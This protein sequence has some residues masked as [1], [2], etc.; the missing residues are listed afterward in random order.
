MSISSVS[1]KWLNRLYKTIAIFLV[2]VAVLISAFRLLL[3]YVENYRSD[4]QDYVNSRNDTNIQIGSLTMT[5]QRFGPSL[6][7]KDV[8]LIETD[9]ASVSIQQLEA[10]VDFWGSLSKQRLV[11][12]NLI[13][14]GAKVNVDQGLWQS[15]EAAAS[16]ATNTDSNQEE[17]FDGIVNLFL[18]RLNEFS[19]L[20]SQI[21]VRNKQLARKFHINNL[22]WLNSGDLHQAQGS[23][24]VNGLSSNNI[25][26]KI[27]LHGEQS[28][29][30]SGQLY[31]Q[32]NHLDITPW[33]DSVLA[34]DNDKTKSDISFAA[35]LNVT[36]SA[37]DRLQIELPQNSI[38]WQVEQVS[39]SLKLGQG[40]LL[41]VKGREPKSFKLFSTPLSLQFNE[42]PQQQLK[43][44]LSKKDNDFS[45]Y[46]SGV[47]LALVGQL[48][49]LFTSEPE[50]RKMLAQLSL[51]G[52][53]HDAYVNFAQG[54]LQFLADFKQ[55][56]NAYSHGIPG[57]SNLAGKLSYA[58]QQLFVSVN[59]ENGSLDFS[60]NFVA[61]IGYQSLSSKLDIAFDDQGWQLRVDALDIVS[62]ELTFAAQVK[63][64]SP[65]EGETTMA[66]L[67]DITRGNAALAGHYYPLN[68]MSDDLVGYLNDA[69][70]SGQIE[71]AAVLVNGPLSHFPFTDGSGIFVVDAELTDSTFK[72]ASD[73]PAITQFD[74]NLNFTNNSMLITG[75][76]GE[77]SGLNV[78]GV[79]AAIDD[80]G[81]EQVLTVAA[82]IKPS[83]ANLVHDLMLAS[84]LKDSVGSVLEQLQI[85]GDIAGEFHLD[86]PLNNSEQVLASGVIHFDDNDVALQTPRMDFSKVNGQLSFANDKITTQDLQLTWHDLPLALA[87]NGINKEAYYDTDIQI[88]TNWQQDNWQAHVPVLLKKYAGGQLPWQGALS[89]HQHHQGG[90]SYQFDLTS[91]FE[92]TKL[93]LPAPYGKTAEQ[94]KPFKVEVTGQLEQSQITAQL[95]NDLS[96]FGIL[97]HESTSFSRAH[98]VLGNEEMLLPMDGFHITTKLDQADFAYWQPLLSD[99]IDTVSHESSSNDGEEAGSELAANK[100]L[101]AKPERIRGTIEQME[102]FG[103][104][105]S[106]ISF[107][108]F[109]KTDWWLLQLN[110]TETRSQLKFY[111]NWHEQGVDINAEFIHLT[112]Q[113]DATQASEAQGVAS[114]SVTPVVDNKVIFANIPPLR[115]HCDRCQIDALDFGQVDFAIERISDEKIQIKQFN[116]Q[117]EQ[118]KLAFTGDWHLNEQSSTTSLRGDMSVDNIEYE[119]NQLGYESIIRDSGGKLDFNLNWHGGPH[120]FDVKALYGAF[121]ARIDDGYL[122]D[123]SDKARI[124]S[125]LSLQSLVRKLTLDFRDI[126]SDGMFYSDIKGE[127]HIE[128]GILYTDRTKMN[129]TAGNLD[130]TGSTDLSTGLL[131][132]KMSYKPNLTSS[133]PVLAWIATLNPVTFLA[134]VAI[135]QVIKSQVVSEFKFE[136]TGTV[137]EPNFQQIERKTKEVRVGRS[138]K[139][140]ILDESEQGKKKEL[141][142]KKSHLQQYEGATDADKSPVQLLDGTSLLTIPTE[143]VIHG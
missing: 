8:I 29:E 77:L 46:F 78:T 7:A 104:Q 20:N 37:I 111:P 30:L 83:G 18:N 135:D 125:I 27:S 19:I 43:V 97:E 140:E 126:F 96:F 142:P 3:P 122:A 85:A 57:M 39:Q 134:G 66:L 75:R 14:T 103:Q 137:S 113:P 69:L 36:N 138:K 68:L 34:I 41:L 44:M 131:D 38:D 32:A 86:L 50:Q 141:P 51:T 105:L 106:N 2:V 63:V 118:A 115:L 65:A 35:W 81:N 127:Y 21:V 61:P 112:S 11:T 67:A 95:G 88:T 17:N 45:A 80:L 108:L 56:S 42:Q 139:P 4:L 10:K 128:Q 117:R 58:H 23:V 82:D 6:V 107:N 130:M 110:A 99:I 62:S 16:S 76:A 60:D 22:N 59:G 121:N 26:L 71:Q 116:A 98:L 1:N 5:W 109:D 49:P 13:L 93:N 87:V 73:W 120:D 64:D 31:L 33:L 48:S 70:V 9:Q 89:L 94:V 124:F 25:Q 119:L 123:V 143:Q 79:K 84:P 114:N 53:M 101:F 74:A 12:S 136:L 28:D 129:G 40:Q 132:Y 54:E 102:I 55:V 90:F 133:L 72:F 52:Q 92:N 100:P 91:Q 24:V 15:N 47:D